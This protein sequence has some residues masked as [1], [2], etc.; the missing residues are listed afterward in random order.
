MKYIFI[1]LTFLVSANSLLGQSHYP[2]PTVKLDSCT[3]C[4]TDTFQFHGQITMASRNIISDFGPRANASYWHG[5]IDY[6]VT[7]NIDHG[8]HIK[9]VESGNVLRVRA[10]VGQK[11]LEVD[12][13]NILM[14]VHMFTSAVVGV[15]GITE[16]DVTLLQ[17]DHYNG[18]QNT[19]GYGILY[20]NASDTVLI[21]RCQNGDCSV[22]GK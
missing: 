14:Y 18:D 15:N 22:I 7:G 11:Y 1:I 12:G 10:G 16:A 17:L 2:G 13:I 19:Y 6:N 4:L 20:L 8:F 3:Y 21:A 9:A 5:G